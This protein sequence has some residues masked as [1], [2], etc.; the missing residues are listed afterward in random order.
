MSKSSNSKDSADISNDNKDIKVI[1]TSFP[2]SKI[3]QNCLNIYEAKNQ[4]LS[5]VTT[6]S[7]KTQSSFQ[8][9]R[10]F[11]SE[12]SKSNVTSISTKEKSYYPLSRSKTSIVT[13]SNIDPS[14]N[15]CQNTT[16]QSRILNFQTKNECLPTTTTTMT[17]TTNAINLNSG[18]NNNN[19]NNNNINI[20][21]INI[22]NIKKNKVLK[23]TKFQSA[24]EKFSLLDENNNNNNQPPQSSR[25][26]QYRSI[27]RSNSLLETNNNS[28]I[29]S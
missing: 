25:Q 2:V 23:E 5:K 26:P 8:V 9:K 22:N 18:M 14:L 29:E 15:A 19:N 1:E 7:T 20:N 24:I 12:V 28:N 16:L 11:S 13:K 4:S 27:N 6:T 17:T 3:V 21:N 10:S